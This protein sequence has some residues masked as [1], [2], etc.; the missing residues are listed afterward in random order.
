MKKIYLSVILL[1]TVSTYAADKPR[2]PAS[3]DCNSKTTATLQELVYKLNVDGTIKQ[4]RYDKMMNSFAA[5]SDC[6]A[7]NELML[8]AVGDCVIK[9][10]KKTNCK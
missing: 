3:L 10:L 1:F 2:F 9:S 6:E 4:S 7:V 5:A 8:A